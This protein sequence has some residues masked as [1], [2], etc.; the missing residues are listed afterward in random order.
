MDGSHSRVVCSWQTGK[1]APSSGSS[2]AAGGGQATGAICLYLMHL[3]RGEWRDAKYWARQIEALEGE[4]CQ[5]APVP[6]EVVDTSTSAAGPDGALTVFLDIRCSARRCVGP[7][8]GGVHARFD[9]VPR[10]SSA[11][12]VA[13]TLS[14]LVRDDDGLH[15]PYGVA[16]AVVMQVPDLPPASRQLGWGAGVPRHW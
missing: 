16:Q 7:G 15:N 6:H 5:C 8:S 13:V 12:L 11:D 14:H 10:L 1:K 3:R 4:P 9:G 2:F